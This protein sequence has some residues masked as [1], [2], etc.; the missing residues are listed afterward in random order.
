MRMET[1]VLAY[2]L[3]AYALPASVKTGAASAPQPAQMDND[4]DARLITIAHG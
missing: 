2:Q 3:M 4:F 1:A